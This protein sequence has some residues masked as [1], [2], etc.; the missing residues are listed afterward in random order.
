MRKL[1]AVCICG[2]VVYIAAVFLFPEQADTIGSFLGIDSWN[3][4]LRN[5]K[6]SLEK[7]TED[8]SVSD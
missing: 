6:Q 5:T 4:Q 7:T 3:E 8:F 2:V 1:I